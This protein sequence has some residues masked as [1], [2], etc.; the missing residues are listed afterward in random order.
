MEN[1]LNYLSRLLK[2]SP[3][4]FPPPLVFSLYAY[5]L[6]QCR[7]EDAPLNL[8]LLPMDKLP[9]EI[10]DSIS[11][12][13]LGA[14]PSENELTPDGYVLS[15]LFVVTPPE[16]IKFG[17]PSPGR[18]SEIGRICD[19]KAK[20]TE[21]GNGLDKIFLEMVDGVAIGRRNSGNAFLEFINRTK[22]K[23]LKRVTP[24]VYITSLRYTDPARATELLNV[25]LDLVLS[26]TVVFVRTPVP[27][28]IVTTKNVIYIEHFD[29]SSEP[30]LEDI[31]RILIEQ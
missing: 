24:N 18:Y 2:I 14:L 12:F 31:K 27:P 9:E 21:I 23:K 17:L 1:T 7:K 26:D 30:V 11:M 4:L 25:E 13:V 8:L 20:G 16:D 5:L 28:D 6:E 15:K 29:E 19:N 10:I 22:G 3:D